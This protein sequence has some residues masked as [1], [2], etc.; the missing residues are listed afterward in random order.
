MWLDSEGVLHAEGLHDPLAALSDDLKVRIAATGRKENREAIDQVRAYFQ[1]LIEDVEASP[2]D[3]SDPEYYEAELPKSIVLSDV[4]A[5]STLGDALVH[6]LTNGPRRWRLE[7]ATAALAGL[8]DLRPTFRG[9]IKRA[10]VRTQ[11]P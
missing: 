2:S 3:L 11:Q 10:L 7:L 8:Y 6:G 9:R 5:E 4:P 1:V